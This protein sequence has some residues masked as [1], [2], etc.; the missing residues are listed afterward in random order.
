MDLK[1]QTKFGVLESFQDGL[2]KL[3]QQNGI[4]HTVHGMLVSDQRNAEIAAE[5]MYKI[6]NR[7]SE[8]V[9]YGRRE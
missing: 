6:G 2:L 7:Y 3:T 4:V 5:Y 8:I 9:K 1:F